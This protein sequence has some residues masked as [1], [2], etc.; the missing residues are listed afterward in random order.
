M[1]KLFVRSILAG[2]V[3]EGILK[4]KQT[5]IDK[6]TPT[7]LYYFPWAEI[8]KEKESKDGK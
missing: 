5:Y 8:K 6:S 3:K 2:A 4:T 1:D 7:T